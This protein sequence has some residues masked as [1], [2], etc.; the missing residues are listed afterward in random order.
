MPKRQREEG[1]E[2]KHPKK[3]AQKS[4]AVPLKA[5]IRK[6]FVPSSAPAAE[7]DFP[8]GGG[9]S[10]TPLEKQAIRAEALQEL[11]DEQIFGVYL[12]LTGLR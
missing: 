11:K 2:S 5:F 4:D 3:K 12:C 10:F 1:A 9:S 6:P 8:R 7:I